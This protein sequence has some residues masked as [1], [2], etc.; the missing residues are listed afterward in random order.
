MKTAFWTS[1]AS[2]QSFIMAS[3]LEQKATQYLSNFEHLNVQG[4]LDMFSPDCENHYA[5][6]SIGLPSPLSNTQFAEHI[7]R[8]GSVFER[9][10]VRATEMHANEAK[11]QVTIRAVS[12][13]KVRP[14]LKDEAFN[15]EE[16]HGEYI[17]FLSFDEAGDEIVRVVEFMDS[18]KTESLKDVF[19]KALAKLSEK[20]GQ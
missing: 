20:E 12:D 15:D 17:Y 1:I 9:F 16:W 7:A 18:V 3:P 13:I 11:K 10:C 2:L 8:M 19:F 4:F 5:P 6:A 14:E